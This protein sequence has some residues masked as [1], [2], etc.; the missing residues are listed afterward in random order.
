MCGRDVNELNDMIAR[1]IDCSY[2]RAYSPLAIA[3]FK[4]YHG[5]GHILADAARGYTLVAVE[6]GTTVGTGTL[7]DGEIKR[8]FVDPGYQGRGLGGEIMRRLIAEARAQGLRSVALHASV[9]SREMYEH[10]G[11]RPVREASL[12]LGGGGTL[13]YTVMILDL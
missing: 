4:E 10:M 5:P 11:F 2:R 7:L 13:D 3:F 6:G 12:D 1:T 8:V 9:V